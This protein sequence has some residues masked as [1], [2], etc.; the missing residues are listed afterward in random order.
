M[1]KNSAERGNDDVC[2]VEGLKQ[3]AGDSNTAARFN[4][5]CSLD[6]RRAVFSQLSSAKDSPQQV[7][8]TQIS[9]ML[10]GVTITGDSAKRTISSIS[11]GSV[12]PAEPMAKA[13]AR[14]ERS[15]KP[16]VR[17]NSRAEAAQESSTPGIDDPYTKSSRDM[18]S[19]EL[20]EK[21]N[22]VREAM[23]S[24]RNVSEELNGL[25]RDEKVRLMA[26]VKDDLIQ[27][28]GAKVAVSETPGPDGNRDLMF[29]TNS[30]AR[31]LLTES[32][33]GVPRDMLVNGK[34]L[35]SELGLRTALGAVDIYDKE[36][37]KKGTTDSTGGSWRD[38]LLGPSLLEGKGPL[39]KL[40]RGEELS[41]EESR[42]LQ[43]MANKP[44]SKVI[45]YGSKK[46]E[47]W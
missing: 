23:L 24:G 30:G 8:G 3:N 15:D 29:I 28:N 17:P 22:K 31:V 36:G 32:K 42:Q 46:A 5:E 20:R 40:Y 1:A 26:V 11:D 27:K 12:A 19:P 25:G 18:A 47:S 13:S 35:T 21:A 37:E 9:K 4:Q 45:I 41:P 39:A 16:A 7:Y 10:D 14:P 34:G 38:R 33:M 43:E 6:D 2:S 44:G